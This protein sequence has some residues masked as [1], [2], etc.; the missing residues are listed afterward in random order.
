M[1]K[2]IG[3]MLVVGAAALI[4]FTMALHYRRRPQQ[5]RQ[6]MHALQRLETEIAYGLTPLPEAFQSI[7]RQ[8]ADPLAA[9][10]RRAAERLLAADG[11]PTRDI[12]SETVNEVWKRTSLGAPEREA[13]LQLGGV[14]GLSDRDDQIKHLRLAVGQLAA[15]EEQSREEHRRYGKMWKS[16][17]VLIGALI[18]IL[19][20]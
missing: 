17:G 19:M 14:L 3:A 5:I 12:W 4:G 13:V 1:L 8:I 7:A 2:L 15:E 16:L 20:Y 10:F 11:A 18:V 6:L 9:L